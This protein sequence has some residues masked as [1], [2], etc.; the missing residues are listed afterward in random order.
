V[1]PIFF[2]TQLLA[3]LVIFWVVLSLEA[4]SKEMQIGTYVVVVA[5]VFLIV[6]GPGVQD[7]G[8]TT[9]DDLISQPLAASWS[10]LLGV[11]MMVTGVVIFYYGKLGDLQN[12]KRKSELFKFSVLLIARSTAFS[13]NLTVS[14]AMIIELSAAWFGATIG[15]KV[16]S[17]MIYTLAIV[18][19][20]TTVEQSTFVPLSAAITILLNAVTGMLVWKDW[21]VVQS[22]PGYICVFFL[23]VLGC[24]LLLGDLNFLSETAPETFL[25]A[26]VGMTL[27]ANRKRLFDNIRNF[28]SD[29]A[30]EK[31]HE[32]DR[33]EAWATVYETARAAPMHSIST[34]TTRNRKARSEWPPLAHTC[35]E[36]SSKEQGSNHDPSKLTTGT[37]VP[38][39]VE[40]LDHDHQTRRSSLS[41]PT[42][43][44]DDFHYAKDVCALSWWR[45]IK[46]LAEGSI[47]DIHLVKRRRHFKEVAY[48]EKRNV[49]DEAK[50]KVIL[51]YFSSK[52]QDGDDDDENSDDVR[53]LKSIIKD[54]IGSDAVLEEMRSEIMVLSHL[55]HPNIVKL[56]EAYERRR[57]V[58]LVM[59]YCP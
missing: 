51:P 21:R 47:S 26:R 27:R 36:P 40:A 3:N 50:R 34:R 18:V 13:T 15:I 4:F 53:V 20:S 29:S 42:S 38:Q 16:V 35:T 32:F 22:W 41:A 8:D 23:L 56:Y 24:T 39:D 45:P 11:G 14:K 19:Q 54:H 31:Q 37:F 49:M 48:K 1:G 52:D 25:G 6:N 30:E 43:L 55:S 5:V 33:A 28:G 10:L 59:E 57:H 9:F 2:A 46:L 44:R 58:Y 12:F 7:Y 17:G